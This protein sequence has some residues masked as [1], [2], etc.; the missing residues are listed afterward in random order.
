VE[1]QLVIDDRG[2]AVLIETETT[3][4]VVENEEGRAVAVQTAVHGLVLG[5]VL[6]QQRQPI[7]AIQASVTPTI[8]EPSHD[9]KDE[10]C[11]CCTCCCV[12]KWTL[13]TILFI[14]CLPFFILYILCICFCGSSSS[15]SD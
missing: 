11:S 10:C 4:V 14:I 7:P 9:E 1:R 2:R 15:N 8:T 13:F 3:G 6:E 5:N 12:V